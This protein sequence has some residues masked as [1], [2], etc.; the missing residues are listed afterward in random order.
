MC[1]DCLQ[2]V[3]MVGPIGYI[4]PGSG[5]MLLQ[6]VAGGAAASAVV[7]KLYWRRLR[8]FLGFSR[9]QDEESPS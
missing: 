6:A 8:R 2:E 5:S 7:A 1:I 3:A 4:D 9:T